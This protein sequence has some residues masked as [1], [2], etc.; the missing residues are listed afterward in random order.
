MREKAGLTQRELA[1]KI[2]QPQ[3]WVHRGEIGSRRVDIAEFIEICR[4]C[5]VDPAAALIELSQRNR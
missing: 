3:W 1:A 5:R 2:G 4:G